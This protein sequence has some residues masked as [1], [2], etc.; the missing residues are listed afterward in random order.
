MKARDVDSV[1]IHEVLF[2]VSRCVYIALI[3]TFFIRIIEHAGCCNAHFVGNILP[4]HSV[5]IVFSLLSQLDSGEQGSVCY[6]C[7][8]CRGQKLLFPEI[9][10]CVWQFGCLVDVARHKVSHWLDKRI[11]EL[12]Q[13]ALVASHLIILAKQKHY[14]SRLILLNWRDTAISHN[15]RMPAAAWST[16]RLI[17]VHEVAVFVQT[18]TTEIKKC[19]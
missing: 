16:I 9:I 1:I 7:A 3:E 18:R 15:V 2:S 17:F 12:V 6:G 14:D 10:C 19:R 4:F 11:V 13:Y 5:V 8:V